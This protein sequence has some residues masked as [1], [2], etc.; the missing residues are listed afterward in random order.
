MLAMRSKGQCDCDSATS[1]CSSAATND[2]IIICLW[3]RE[4]NHKQKVT[5]TQALSG[6]RNYNHETSN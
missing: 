6:E 5:T 1:E 4:G 2:N 3:E